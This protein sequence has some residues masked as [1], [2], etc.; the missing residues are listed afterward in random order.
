MIRISESR[1]EGEEQ[2]TEEVN[3]E[4]G[5]QKSNKKFFP[6]GSSYIVTSNRISDMFERKQMIIN[7]L[8][9]AYTDDD[10]TVRTPKADEDEEH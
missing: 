7:A 5:L 2:I 4:E 3:D 6:R 9:Q 10:D 1:I 8:N